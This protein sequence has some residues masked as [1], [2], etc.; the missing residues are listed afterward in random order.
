[1]E[2]QVTNELRGDSIQEIFVPVGSQ[3][4]VPPYSVYTYKGEAIPLQA[5]RV[6]GG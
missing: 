1:L 5:L 4:L 6:P 3:Y 2:T